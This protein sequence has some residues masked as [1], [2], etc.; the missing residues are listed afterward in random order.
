MNQKKKKTTSPVE[1]TRYELGQSSFHARFEELE[2]DHQWLL[3]QIK[4]KRTELTNF[5][6]Q[7]RSIATDIFQRSRPF[8][9]KLIEL[10]QEIHSIFEE[11]LTKRKFN[12]KSRFEVEN[13]YKILQIIGVI[14]PKDDE[15]DENDEDLDENDKQE[16]FSDH[17]TDFNEQEFYSQEFDPEDNPPP[18][19]ENANTSAD[20]KQMRQSFLRLA[21]IFHPD[22]VSNQENK[23]DYAE[24][25]KEINRAYEE[26]DM[27]RL[28]E[29]ERQYH[30]ENKIDLKNASNSEIEKQCDRMAMDN[31]ILATQYENIKAELR[32]MRRTPEG[33]MVKEYRSLVRQGYDPI[34]SVIAESEHHLNKV[35]Q[36]RNFVA[37]FRDRK[38]TL[39]EFI[40]GPT[41]SRNV[42]AEYLEDMLDDISFELFR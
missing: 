37:D 24:I 18:P 26:G 40:K 39:K 2:K 32:W 1:Q 9:E 27:A 7:M 28:L 6:T 23:E 30:L 17:D 41:F 8:H 13:V 29:I 33:E 11:I 4:R 12:K 19:Q 14:S 38:I 5:L 34:E 22:K 36:V 31:Q 35:E 20:L 3:K 21:S 42:S 25:M 15:D 16:D 10:D